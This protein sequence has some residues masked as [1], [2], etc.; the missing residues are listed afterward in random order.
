MSTL[1]QEKTGVTATPQS[2]I[3]FQF[4]PPGNIN[5]FP[6]NPAAYKRLLELW[7]LNLTGFTEQAMAGNT[8]NNQNTPPP[9]NYYNPAFTTPPP[10]AGGQGIEWGPFPGRFQTYFGNNSSTPLTPQQLL[11]L[12][13]TGYYTDGQGKKQTF[14]QITQSPCSAFDSQYFQSGSCGC[15]GDAAVT[16]P[17]GP[18][19]PRGW[20]DEY[21][22]WCVTRDK[23]GNITRI[24]FTCE[25][26]EYWNTLW[27]VDPQTV[28]A[29][30]QQTLGKPQITLDDLYLRDLYGQPVM[31]PGTGLPAYNPLNKWNSGPYGSTTQG[32]A[33][34]LTSTPNTIQTEIGLGAAA[35]VLR[36]YPNGGQIP[37]NDIQ[38]LICSAQ[39]GQYGRNSD[40][41]IGAGVNTLAAAGFA[42]TL[43][44]P[45][46][47]YIQMP[48]NLNADFS[49][50][51]VSDITPYFTVSRKGNT[52]TVG[53]VDY[54]L[55]LH[56]TVEAPQGMPPLSEM[57]CAGSGPLQWAGQIAQKL[58]MVI[59]ASA[60]KSKQQTPLACSMPATTGLHAQ[61][62]QLF[63][64]V[65]FSAMA[66]TDVPNPV[67]FPMILLS[68]ST[69]VSP[70]VNKGKT[71]NM[72]VTYSP[73][74]PISSIHPAD[75]STWP[76]VSFDDAAITAKATH[77]FT[78]L[79]YAV[80]GN[81]Y[82]SPC[83]AVVLT[84]TVGN[85]IPTGLYGVFMKDADE[86]GQGPVMPALLHVQ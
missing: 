28:L 75:P 4:L 2:A 63:H 56:L 9:P 41:N 55:N 71:Y 49:I 50:Q 74:V 34:H 47:L 62:L 69:Y 13:D 12:G 35:T 25:N 29:L 26:P 81:S 64:E 39:Y 19:G 66:S 32:G 15:V 8:W 1:T 84:V 37:G 5:D 59:L 6:N 52:V 38:S 27:L 31:D 46:G 78:T 36:N 53:N 77:V 3:S 22:E 82:P 24:D 11:E 14:P 54:T 42:I 7:N 17:Y 51:G 70:I 79:K 65:V 83:V 23:N 20:Q 86:V 57:Q 33:M 43:Y 40:P 72:V 58:Q 30:Y 61:P 68:N 85:G 10:N 48:Q 73:S 21:C 60:F 18:Y 16:M 76:T 45:P 80:P 67:N 44:N